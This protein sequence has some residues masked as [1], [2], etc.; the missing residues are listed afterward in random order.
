MSSLK[1]RTDIARIDSLER[2]WA[3]EKL[4]LQLEIDRLKARLKHAE[5]QTTRDVGLIATMEERLKESS[6]SATT[7]FDDV[8]GEHL[9][10]EMNTSRKS[11]SVTS[12]MLLI[13]VECKL[14]D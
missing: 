13:V 10:E 11:L 9:N 14:F 8:D 2:A 1:S 5:E 12:E 7:D 4:D 3:E 6:T